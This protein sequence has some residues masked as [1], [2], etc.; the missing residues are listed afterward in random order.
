M[1]DKLFVFVTNVLLNNI[2]EKCRSSTI[3][4]ITTTQATEHEGM[5]KMA[6][7]LRSFVCPFLCAN[8]PNRLT[9]NCSHT[10]L[11]KPAC[12]LRAVI[13]YLGPTKLSTF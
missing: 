5:S 12:N 3:Y 7:E 10:L 4:I 8:Y 9:P 6:P 11:C 1:I 13:C 2:N